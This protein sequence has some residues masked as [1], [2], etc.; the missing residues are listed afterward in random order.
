MNIDISFTNLL[1]YDKV[2][3]GSFHLFS[4]ITRIKGLHFRNNFGSE[5]V[6]L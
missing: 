5:D 6:I 3:I 2:E 4:P 1:G